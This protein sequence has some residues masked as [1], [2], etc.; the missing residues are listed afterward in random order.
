MNKAILIFITLLF[1]ASSF[2]AEVVICRKPEIN[3]SLA[4]IIKNDTE[5]RARKKDQVVIYND[6]GH[7]IAAGRVSKVKG[8]HII[9]LFNPNDRVIKGYKAVIQP[10]GEED[11]ISYDSIF[12]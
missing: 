6:K 10:F 4:C 9:A 3:R 5:H 8:S 2:G 1:A 7:W 12:E 11:I